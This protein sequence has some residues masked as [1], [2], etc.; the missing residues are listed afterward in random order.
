MKGKM[1]ASVSYHFKR[2]YESAAL[3]SIGVVHLLFDSDEDC[4]A[5]PLVLVVTSAFDGVALQGHNETIA[6]FTYCGKYESKSQIVQ[7]D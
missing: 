5:A 7:R 2:V 1:K 6:A 3:Y 4:V